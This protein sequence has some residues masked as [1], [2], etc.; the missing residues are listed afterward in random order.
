MDVIHKQVEVEYD[1]FQLCMLFGMRIILH[2]HMFVSVILVFI[3]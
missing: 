2:G 3:D 1:L